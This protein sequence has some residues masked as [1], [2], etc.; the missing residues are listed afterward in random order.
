MILD[1]LPGQLRVREAGELAVRGRAQLD[2]ADAERLHV[3][4]QSREVAVLDALPMRVGLAPDRQAQRIRLKLSRAEGHERGRG[5]RRGG[6]LQKL[7]S[8]DLGHLTPLRWSAPS[9]RDTRAGD[10]DSRRSH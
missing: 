4:A 1:D 7:T 10:T 8:R 6:L 3:A 5:G 9:R 2:D